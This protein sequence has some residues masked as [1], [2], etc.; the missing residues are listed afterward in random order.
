MMYEHAGITNHMYIFNCKNICKYSKKMSVDGGVSNDL[1]PCPM[2]LK[3]H[4]HG[5]G[6]RFL[7]AWAQVALENPR[8]ACDHSLYEQG[9]Y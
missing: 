5:C 9:D 1:N 2:P 7:W 6:H 4:A 8:V 3:P